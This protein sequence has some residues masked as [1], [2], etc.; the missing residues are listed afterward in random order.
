M[1]RC[2]KINL[3]NDIHKQGNFKQNQDWI[4]QLVL[5]G[6]AQP[7]IYTFGD[8]IPIPNY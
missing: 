2:L 8:I 1:T 7:F 6:T 5:L 4:P 3:G